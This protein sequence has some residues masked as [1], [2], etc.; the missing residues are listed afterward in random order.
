MRGFLSFTILSC[1][2]LAGAGWWLT[3]PERVE[4]S[5]YAGLVGVP[6]RGEVVFHA[7]GC[8]S[9]HSAPDSSGAARLILSGG[10]A[11][12]SDFGTFHAPNISQ[13]PDHGI[14]AWDIIDLANA[15]I[16]GTSP[17]GQHYYPAFPYTSYSRATAQDI[18]DLHAYMV[19]LPADATP[20][21]PHDLA[22]PF[23]LRRGL[24]LWKALYL[25]EDWTLTSELTDTEERG[26]YLTEALGHCAEC[27]TPRGALGA[28]D[29]SRWMAGAPN[30][31]GR[32]TI[33]NITPA[34]LDWSESDI[35]AYFT[36]G[37]TPDYDT[38][39]GSMAA[40]VEGL[41]QLTEDDRA[42]LAAYLKRLPPID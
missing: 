32:G 29:R 16:H 12:V 42:A 13:D 23:T 34:K 22:F 14:G 28:L 3:T 36:S 11:F 25:D 18:V 4:P 2:V 27:H 6:A 33:P 37:F 10:R 31:S 7:G 19:T 9:C 24:G 8:A 38:A 39:G 35:V 41:S 26:R 30:P 15:M 1:L 20:D 5:A 17:Q 40:V 21:Q